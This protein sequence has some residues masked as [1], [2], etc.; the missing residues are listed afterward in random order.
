MQWRWRRKTALQRGVQDDLDHPGLRQRRDQIRDHLHRQREYDV[1]FG[2]RRVRVRAK[3]GGVLIRLFL[4]SGG[5]STKLR[6]K[7]LRSELDSFLGDIDRVL[8][9]PYA[10]DDYDKYVRW[11]KKRKVIGNRE[12]Y[13]IHKCAN[14]ERAVRDAEAIFI[15]GGNTF[16]LL[17]MMYEKKLLN[18]I[19]N[20]IR[21]GIPYIGVSAG[22]NVACPTIMTTNDMPIVQPPSL[23]ALGLVPFQIN[24]HYF[25]GPT[26]TKW[27]GKFTRYAGETRDDRIREFHEMNTTDVIGL[28]EGTILKME[29]GRAK[30]LGAERKGATLFHRGKKPINLA[31]NRFFKT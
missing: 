24:P 25:G 9:I 26:F 12:L 30:L 20:R 6:R 16:R 23:K 31:P 11:M 1:P 29:N 22:T 18:P 2:L 19:R 28:W 21:R 10:L 13:G 17:N 7:L 3:T 15:G 4:G 27:N 14:A 5:F 8:F